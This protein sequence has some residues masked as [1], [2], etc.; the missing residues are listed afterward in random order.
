[1]L[2]CAVVDS[3]EISQQFSF[4][5]RKVWDNSLLVTLVHC[6]GEC[7]HRDG[8][9][10]VC[11]VECLRFTAYSSSTH[12][13]HPFAYTFEPLALVENQ[14]RRWIQWHFTSN[15]K[16]ASHRLPQELAFMI[17]RYCMREYAIAAVW[18]QSA[19]PSTYSVDLASGI[20]ACYIMIDGT[21][22]IASLANKPSPGAQLILGV[23]DA[24]TIHQIY[25]AE[26]HLG[27]QHIYFSTPPTLNN[28]PLWWRTL[29]IYG[30]QLCM[31]TDV[32]FILIFFP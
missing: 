1:M 31:H 8:K 32:R 11:H 14:R 29:Y 4:G 6:Q 19:S 12:S 2:T 25:V 15:L 18:L 17:A 9:A 10:F 3:G 21:R 20:W 27:I 22:Y 13:L 24:I 5:T 28:A 7:P 26:D 16:L 30:A 23:E